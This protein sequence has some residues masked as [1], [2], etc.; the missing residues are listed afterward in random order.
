MSEKNKKLFSVNDIPF[1]LIHD[2]CLQMG[3][4]WV[5][6]G[7]DPV[8]NMTRL[9]EDRQYEKDTAGHIIRINKES[10]EKIIMEKFEVTDIELTTIPDMKTYTVEDL[11]RTIKDRAFFEIFPEDN[12]E[13]FIKEQFVNDTSVSDRIYTIKNK[14]TFGELTKEATALSLYKKYNAAKALY[15]IPMIMDHPTAKKLFEKDGFGFIFYIESSHSGKQETIITVG[16]TGAGK[17]FLDIGAVN[18]DRAIEK[19]AVVLNDTFHTL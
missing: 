19:S 6:R 16:R 18:P 14:L 1:T 13:F 8:E 10:L 3:N 4:G 5:R 7:L 17:T 15:L 12:M 9:Y 11:I 2:I